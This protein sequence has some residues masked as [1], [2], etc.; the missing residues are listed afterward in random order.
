M[1][2]RKDASIDFIVVASAR[3]LCGKLK[4]SE[5]MKDNQHGRAARLV[6]GKQDGK[7]C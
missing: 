3:K 1:R 7:S 5:L 6:D 2:F 4:A